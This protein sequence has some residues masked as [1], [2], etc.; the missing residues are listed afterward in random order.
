M[1]VGRKI[2]VLVDAVEADTAIARGEADA[3]QI[4]GVVRIEGG[5]KLRAGDWAQVQV[6][7]ADAYDLTGRLAP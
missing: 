4:D 6:T 1:R 2:K 3:P 5:G 7:S